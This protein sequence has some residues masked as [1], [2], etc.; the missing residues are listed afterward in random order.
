MVRPLQLL[1]SVSPRESVA[2]TDSRFPGACGPCGRGSSQVAPGRSC[3]SCA[4]CSR[5]NSKSLRTAC[6]FD[7][8]HEGC[9]EIVYVV[10]VREVGAGRS[11]PL[12]L[13]SRHHC[14]LHHCQF[15]GV[16][17]PLLPRCGLPEWQVGAP[18]PRRLPHQCRRREGFRSCRHSGP[19]PRLDI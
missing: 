1:L 16:V 19:L 7:V 13:P 12:S 14:L 3:S 15:P 9:L 4:S 10:V 6:S 18:A 11:E 17:F 8:V 5:R 2:S